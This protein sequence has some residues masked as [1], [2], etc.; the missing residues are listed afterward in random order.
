M[1]KKY[2]ALIGF[3]GITVASA[4]AGDGAPATPRVCT[5]QPSSTAEFR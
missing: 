3:L 1:M 5:E 2:L 4:Y